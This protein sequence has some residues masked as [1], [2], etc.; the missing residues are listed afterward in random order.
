VDH[1]AEE[2]YAAA[3]IFI[4]RAVADLNGVFNAI[5]KS[6]M[7]CEI[8]CYRTEIQ[9]AGAEVLLAGIP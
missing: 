4:E 9:T 5:T 2:E 6:E 3:G 8:K 1:L 7:T